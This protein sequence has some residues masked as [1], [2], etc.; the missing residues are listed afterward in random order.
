LLGPAKPRSVG[1]LRDAGKPVLAAGLG[2]AT[3]VGVTVEPA[4]GSAQPTA[5][6]IL[7]VNLPA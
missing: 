2:D 6:P 4:G 1:L 5:P 7:A 3:Q